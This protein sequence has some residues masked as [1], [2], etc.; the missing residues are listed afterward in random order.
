[1]VKVVCW[2]VFAGLLL[3]G[4]LVNPGASNAQA[5][6]SKSVTSASS[7]QPGSAEVSRE[8]TD[9]VQPVYP[10]N[11]G[12]EIALDPSSLVP[13]LPQLPSSKASLIGGTVA[14]VDHIRDEITI[15]VFGGGKVKT[16]FDPRTHIYRD[17]KAAS[18]TDIQKGERVYADTML[19]DG[20]IFARN[21][22]IGAQNSQGEG[23]GVVLSYRSNDGSLV[24]RDMLSPKP[25]NL[26]LEPDTR[27]VR[28]H[29]S[30]NARD[31]VPGTLVSVQFQNQGGHAIARQV[32]ILIAPGAEFSFLGRV[33]T[34]DLHLGLLVVSSTIDHKNYEIYLDPGV[35]TPDDDL[36]EGAEVTILARY[37]GSRYVAR[38]ITI[39]PPK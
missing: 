28:S 29:Q 21:L 25:L 17:G 32:S 2:P 14:R 8:S 7:E 30:A 9:S 37:D 5:T 36:R 24:L 26:R 23:Q 34:L 33:L 27:I 31:L 10:A 1:M 13:D 20:K 3:T 12:P 15:Q 18:V 4:I 19:L 6:P 16:L 22:R 11:N 38:G 35:T 39:E